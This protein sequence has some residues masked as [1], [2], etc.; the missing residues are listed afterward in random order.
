MTGGNL[1]NWTYNVMGL[2]PSAIYSMHK[3]QGDPW[4]RARKPGVSKHMIGLMVENRSA[5][6]FL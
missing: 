3:N 6:N 1:G 5:L 4:W 2:V